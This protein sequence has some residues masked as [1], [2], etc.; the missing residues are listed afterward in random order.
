MVSTTLHSGMEAEEKARMLEKVLQSETFARSERLKNLLRFLCEAEIGG[1]ESELNE[2]AIATMA[3]GRPESFAP[4]EDS[5]VRSR[6]H[7]LRQ[8]LEKYYAHEAPSAAARIELRKGSYVPRFFVAPAGVVAVEN[9]AAAAPVAVLAPLEVVTKTCAP[10]EPIPAASAAAPNRSVWAAAAMAFS[11][12]A[13]VMFTVLAIWSSGARPGERVPGT[14]LETASVRSL[15]T[16]ELETLWRPFIEGGAPVL[17][18]FENRFFVHMGPLVVRDTKVNSLDNV[19]DSELLTRVQHLFGIRQLYGS[20]N[21]TDVGSPQALFYLTRLLSSR[22]GSISVKSSLNVTADD[23]R[24]NN[25]IL[26][27]KPWTDPEI[28]RTLSQAELID[29]NGKIRNVHPAPGEQAEYKDDNDPTDPNRWTVKYS[30]I[31]L[32]P[33]PAKGRKILTLTGSGSEQ[34][35]ALAYYM[36]SPD[37]AGELL[38]RMKLTSGR[39]PEYFQ[40]LVRAEFKSLAPIKVDYVIHRAL[41]TR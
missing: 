21:Y 32:M 31:T 33:G 10:A 16:P 25:I 34:P 7:E 39:L 30:V 18:A 40:I 20:W 35:S 9:G 3:L 41:K 23:L 15:W 8:K 37:S 13:A 4:L 17:I 36:T 14:Y 22:I 12:G 26:V 11:A 29:V 24:S 2:Y 28:D 27:G 5:S 6:V 38:K 1:R 19:E